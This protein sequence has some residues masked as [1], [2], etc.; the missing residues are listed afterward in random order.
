MS[1]SLQ[2]YGLLAGRLQC[3][4]D[5]VGKNTGMHCHFLLQILHANY[6]I[7]PDGLCT[8]SHIP[9]LHMIYS[10]GHLE[11]PKRVLAQMVSLWKVPGRKSE[12]ESQDFPTPP[13]PAQ[14]RNHSRFHQH[15]SRI[16]VSR[17]C[18][19]PSSRDSSELWVP[20]DPGEH[21]GIVQ[22]PLAHTQPWK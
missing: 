6:S 19:Q 20:G 21:T 5:F 8:H 1:D 14:L 12:P 22:G 2:P 7:L 11:L 10:H 17:P 16:P 3:S 4:W 18:P 9:T 15:H 13:F